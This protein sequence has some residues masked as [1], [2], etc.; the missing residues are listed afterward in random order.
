M[1][2]PL[3]NVL[4]HHTG[5]WHAVYAVGG[6]MNAIAALLGFFV[7]RPLINSEAPASLRWE[8]FGVPAR[9]IYSHSGL[10]EQ[11][12]GTPGAHRRP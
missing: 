1:L 12:Q 9:C 6:A 10:M 8:G 2:V 3:G 5:S 7:L 11:Y 4:T